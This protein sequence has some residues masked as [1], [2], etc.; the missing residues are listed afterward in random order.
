MTND[1]KDLRVVLASKDIIMKMGKPHSQ[2]CENLF[3][4]NFFFYNAKFA[5]YLKMKKEI[6]LGLLSKITK[7]NN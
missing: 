4:K 1:R 7:P 5:C 3:V 2:S 6:D